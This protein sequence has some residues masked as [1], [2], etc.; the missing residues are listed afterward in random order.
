MCGLLSVTA[1]L[2]TTQTRR[3]IRH[4]PTLQSCLTCLKIGTSFGIQKLSWSDL[5]IAVQ[6]FLQRGETDSWKEWVLEHASD[7]AHPLG[8]TVRFLF[9]I[10]LTALWSKNVGHPYVLVQET[11]QDGN[12]EVSADKTE[13]P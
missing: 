5:S 7:A 13:N 12:G 9:V 8:V 10:L 4:K 11:E 2:S 6:D 3:L 1:F